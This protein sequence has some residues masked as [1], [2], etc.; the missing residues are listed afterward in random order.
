[1]CLYINPDGN[2]PRIDKTAYE[3]PIAALIGE[4]NLN[5]RKKDRLN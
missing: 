1:M 5:V 2:Y 3:A 4:D